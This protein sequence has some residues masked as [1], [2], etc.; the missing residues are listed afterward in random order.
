MKLTKLLIATGL[1]VLSANSVMASNVPHAEPWTAKEWL[2]TKAAMPQGDIDKGKLLAQEGYCYSCHGVGGNNPT[3]STPSL[4]GQN[5]TYTYKM[6]LDYK[7][8]RFY[9]DHKSH[10][11]VN[12]MQYYNE[13]QMADM[14]AYFAAQPLPYAEYVEKDVD[15]DP[16]IVRLV[17]KGD[18]SR[19]IVPC[20]SCHGAHGEGGMNETPALTGLSPRMF[21]RQMQKYK[22]GERHNDVNAGMAQFTKELTDD[23]IKALADYYAQLKPRGVK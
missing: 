16:A 12:V 19:M 2:E 15:V 1:S 13:Q 10:V 8:G 17:A 23:E 18:T 11:M 4:A 14:A 6:L 21:I 3:Q 7:S 22:D 9:V 5:A 20:A